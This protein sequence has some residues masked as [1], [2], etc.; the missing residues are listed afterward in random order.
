[1]DADTGE[2][3]V[4][5]QLNL[6]IYSGGLINSR[7]REARHNFQ[8]AQENLTQQRRDTAKQARDAY[9]NVISGI[10]RVKALK[11]AVESQQAGNDATEAGFE[12]GT[13][14]SVDVLISLRALFQAERDYSVARYAY[15]VDTLE[16]KQA[17]GTLTARD[18]DNIN[19]WL[20]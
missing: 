11:R 5:V 18:V 19:Q 6:P 15:L 4:G 1:M 16:L 9:L 2:L 20:D 7:T 14:T 13:R 8:D 3:E 12:V 10:S 17:A